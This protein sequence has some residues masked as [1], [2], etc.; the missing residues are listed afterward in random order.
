MGVMVG[1]ARA[2]LQ[3]FLCGAAESAVEITDFRPLS[4]GA[5]QDNRLLDISVAGGAWAGEHQLVL[6]MDAKSTVA[7]SH[8]RAEEFAVLKAAYEAGVTVPK[9][10]LLVE[11]VGVLG[12]A[13]F[14]MHRVDGTAAGH[15]L[16]KRGPMEGLAAEL[17]VQLARIHSITHK[18]ASLRFL[19]R[20]KP[21]P[22]LHAVAGYRCD[23]DD[24]GQSRPALEWGLRWLEL[25]APERG[26]VVLCHRDFR[27]GNYMVS[28]DGALT[29]ILDWEFAGWGDPEEDIGWFLAKCWRFGALDREAG[30][31]ARREPFIDAYEKESGRSLD[32]R[33][34]AYWQV[35]AQVR[36]AVIAC[37]Q[38]YRH[39]SGDEES[40]ELAMTQH[41]VPELELEV[42][43]LTEGKA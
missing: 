10:C 24:L 21:A 6:R 16:V 9:P 20:P 39:V 2:R 29:G 12:R 22:S 30:G 38:A 34:I 3:D 32:V 37:Q 26:A 18:V 31:I 13:F 25:N 28:D 33:C 35:M 5:I 11:D 8:G 14:I 41:I 19:A 4:G 27:T 7:M 40:L 23:L 42:L 15:K 1:D 17:G 43:N 36:W